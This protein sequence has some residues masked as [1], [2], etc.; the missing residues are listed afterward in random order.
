MTS[1]DYKGL[2]KK[3]KNR[4]NLSKES[5]SIKDGKIAD[6]FTCTA[7]KTEL[8]KTKEIYA[9]YIKCG[10]LEFCHGCSTKFDALTFEGLNDNC[11]FYFPS[12]L[13]EDDEQSIIES[14]ESIGTCH[15][16]WKVLKSRRLQCWGNFPNG[17]IENDVLPPFLKSL[18]DDLVGNSI[19]ESSLRPD[20][21]LINQYNENEGIMHH[22]DGPMYH[23]KVALLSLGSDVILSF[24]KRLTPDQIGK[25]FSGDVYSVIL[26]RRSLFVFGGILYSEFM[27]GI[28]FHPQQIVQE[29]NV[30]VNAKLLGY[31]PGDKISKGVRTSLTFRKVK[32]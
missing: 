22:T 12:V 31:K 1:I 32:I 25:E 16:S 15:T 4:A 19:C 28:D 7:V 2:L 26:K 10:S 6:K 17:E 18:V 29:Y 11:N 3:E 23:E 5:T 8:D 9:D 20:N 30:C 27:H 14:I 21:I 13:S 24:R